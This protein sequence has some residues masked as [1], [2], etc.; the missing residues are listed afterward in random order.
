MG[1]GMSKDTEPAWG[2][3][4]GKN[5]DILSTKLIKDYNEL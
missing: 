4:T 3:P 5:W 1:E 2:A